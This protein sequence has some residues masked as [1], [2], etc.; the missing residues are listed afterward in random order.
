MTTILRITALLLFW[1][2]VAPTKVQAQ[3]GTAF[4]CDGTFYQIRQVGTGTAAYSALF[5][6]NRSTAVYTTNAYTFGGTNATGNLGR[7]LNALGYN[8]QDGFMYAV[9]YP[10][11][12]GDPAIL[13]D[14][15]HLFRIGQGGI[16]DLGR[17]NLPLAQ[18]NS[19][20]FDK[21]G[22]YYLTTRNSTD[23]TYRNT[24]FR[25][26][27]ANFATVLTSN[28]QF[29]M[30]DPQGGPADDNFTDIGYNPSD[31]TLYSVA[32]LGDVSRIAV[33]ATNAVVTPISSGSTSAEI[34]GSSFFDISGN[35]YAYS[36]GTVGT[37]NSAGLYSINL[38]TGAATLISTVDAANNSD[39]A[40]C[41]NPDQRIDV[42]KELIS[43]VPTGTARQ[44]NVR[45]NIRVKNTGTSTAPN[46]QVSDF[47][48]GNT[49]NT[50]FPTSSTVTLVA[51]SGSVTNFG[52]NAGAA[53]TL[54]FNTAFNG[55]GTNTDLLTGTQALTAGQSA[56]IDFTV[57]VTFPAT[58]GTPTTVQNNYAYA[59]TIG[60]TAA[61]QGHVQ[62]TNGTILPPG[63]LLAE[64][65][66]NN[67]ASFP[68][69]P[70]G[71]GETPTP[72]RFQ[73][74]IQGT[75]FE[76]VNFGG[77]L[78]RTQATSNGPG[79]AN[80]RVELYGGGGAFL[81]SVLTDA[82]GNYEFTTGAGGAALGIN[83]NYQVRVVNSSVFSSRP[84]PNG[85][86][87]VGV[88]TYINGNNN[89]VGGANP[90]QVDVPSN[91]AG[92]SIATL[93]NQSAT[94]I[95]QSLTAVTTPASGP[96]T[97]VDFGY[98]FDLVVN[99]NSSGQGS[100]AQFI[101][102][103]SY[104]ANTGLAQEGLTAGKE[105]A[106]FM[107][108]NGIAATNGMRGAG[109]ASPGYNAT[110]GVFTITL[111]SA[112]EPMY[113]DDT[114]IDG[115]LQSNRTG[116]TATATAGTSTGAE[117]AIDF[118]RNAGLISYGKNTRIASLAM[119]N[120]L[121]KGINSNANAGG[122]AIPAEGTAITF[123]GANSTGS[124][125][126][127][128][129]TTANFTGGVRLQSGATGVTVS[130]NILRT[131]VTNGSDFNFLASDGAGIVVDG[132][133]TN[134]ISGNTM[135][136]NAG[137]G[138]VLQNGSSTNT[139]STNTITSN[140]AG[141]FT[142]N[143]AGIAILSG[144]NNLISANTITTN[145]GDGIV[146]MSGTSGNRFT[147]N[148]TGGNNGSTATGNLG[149]D[150]SPNAT[151]TGDGV[152][153][154]ADG[155]TAASGANSMLNF[156]VF[157]QAT[158]NAGRLIVSGYARAGALIE[159]FVASA[160]PTNFGEGS[161]Y[162]FNATEG[163]SADTDT[164]FASYTG[165]QA[166]LNHGSETGVSRFVFS[167]PVTATQ[168]TS[169][170]ANKL[171]AT[172]TVPT[173]VNGL[174][175]GNTS[176]FSGVIAVTNNAPLPVELTKF[177]V[178]A[179]GQNAQLTW[180][181]ASETNN[182]HFVVERAYGEQAFTTIATVKGN[183]TSTVGHSYSFTDAGIGAKARGTIYYRLKQVDTDGTVN[184]GPVR[185]V[186]FG[187]EVSATA[188]TEPAVYPN[189][190]VEDTQLDLTSLPAGSYQVSLVDATGRTLSTETYTGGI[191]HPFAARH[192]TSG[193][194][195]V[196][197]RGNNVKL[198]K[199]LVKN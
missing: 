154:N 42:V 139:I 197:I 155:K 107:I 114:V 149:I 166:G 15:I 46:V 190:V 119:S 176:E 37:A 71:D 66:S 25:L 60:G 38:S 65:R 185:T 74:A 53:P 49:V 175:V 31:N 170:V 48:R 22:N 67:S 111:S 135:N 96:L 45:F 82:N 128:V 120:A 177:D 187:S 188:L 75:V 113:D 181:T 5:V 127:D 105:H 133:S 85:A 17:T 34:F 89:Q 47:L 70:N 132:S 63:T 62:L 26:N 94:T 112:F 169:L 146:A 108:N 163:S 104:L 110:T 182:D 157:T 145:S 101:H 58:P 196:V 61:N 115:K 195:L 193:S 64:D 153:L 164:R 30:V 183:G 12:N 81:T 78:G 192:L 189:P 178:R 161:T 84:N 41:I 148:N 174:A 106:I 87:T 131:G 109:F 151:A 3:E 83:T 57:T 103:S 194:Y 51:N 39:G 35:M 186:Q 184:Q 147:Q 125:V 167:I 27:V 91:G 99:T 10:S 179:V 33:G 80:V 137:Y 95:V 79:L 150:L 1:L 50:T 141:T 18:Y 90:N 77:G 140:G 165:G 73:T 160:D 14:G 4:S 118:N 20:T 144:N 198:A 93:Q 19:G 9:S 116:E 98:N 143:D 102:N 123:S 100:L 173:T 40:S 158:I 55:Q 11:D 21:S 199:R 23:A 7:V 191:V 59:S 129:T 36:N 13:P 168:I 68:T 92:A 117:I 2:V 72:V 130:N 86:S 43:V 122:A 69:T 44:F 156:P 142:N 124:V 121:G 162:L 126:T 134:T 159:F 152:S 8:S 24:L 97:S 54:A 16:R 136:S 172:A 56:L 6:V 180:A 32:R 171:T 28:T 88:Q 52:V 29:P 138:I 76:D